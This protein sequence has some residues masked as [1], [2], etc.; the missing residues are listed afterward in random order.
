MKSITQNQL[1][2]LCESLECYLAN[3]NEPN[4]ANGFNHILTADENELP[5]EFLLE[6]LHSWGFCDYLVPCAFGGKLNDLQSLYLLVK[7]I[8]R[9]DVT[10]AILR[11]LSFFSA[12]PVFLA[13][14]EPQK[15]L[16]A[17]YLAQGKIG[18]IALTEKDT[19]SDLSAIATYAKPSQDGWLLNGSKWSINHA[20][21]SNTAT[22]LART[23]LTKTPLSLSLFLLDKPT[24]MNG[25]KAQPRLPLHGARGLDVSGFQLNDVEIAHDSIIGKKGQGLLIIYRTLQVSRTLCASMSIG[26]ADSC[27]RMAVSF[28]QKRRLYGKS[29]YDIQAVK[30]RL[31][32]SY[33][34]LLAADSLAIAVTRAASIYPNRLSL[35]SSMV[36]FF[37]PKTCEFIIEQTALVIGA[38]GFIRTG[39]FA[40]FQKF[41]RDNQLIGLFDGSSEVN[42]NI[43][44][45]HLVSQTKKREQQNITEK[46]HTIFDL[47][48]ALPAIL[49]DKLVAFSKEHDVLA[50]EHVIKGKLTDSHGK[51]IKR[52]KNLVARILELNQQGD[53]D[54]QDLATMRLAEDYCWL[55]AGLC[56]INFFYY[57]ASSLAK[58]LEDSAW[59]ELLITLILRRFE[60]DLIIENSL[61]ETV[62]SMLEK[63]VNSKSMLSILPINI[64]R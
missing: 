64:A 16:M 30:Q 54:G 37:A 47:T 29:A 56:A 17:R 55:V 52:L 12:L 6:N 44:A 34:L 5:P 45:N 18:C 51:L 50:Q 13:G 36:K 23:S 39:E 15:K 22:I 2:K 7:C 25:F 33:V 8:S 62:S 3:P 31:S 20:R 46:T 26:A 14:N 41:R 59:L 63:T 28:S 24:L 48:Q 27:L 43:I 19:G 58:S 1:I 42:L 4:N 53:F 60:P 40:L 9:R 35:W 11:G 10:A 32:E 57:S 49:L 38:R 21:K 61:Y